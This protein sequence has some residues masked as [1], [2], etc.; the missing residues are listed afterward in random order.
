MTPASDTGAR[1]AAEPGR[2][3]M[4][5]PALDA[6]SDAAPA[7]VLDEMVAHPHAELEGLLDD[8]APLPPLGALAVIRRGLAV[9]PELRRGIRVSFGFAVVAAIG[10]LTVPILVQQVLQHGILGPDGFR[11][12]YVYSATA[13]A[14]GIIALVLWLS[15]M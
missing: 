7:G 13:L 1:R 15:R 2:E 10:K 4:A 3:P 14:V 5:G 8:D 6:L 9:S 11:P 12:A